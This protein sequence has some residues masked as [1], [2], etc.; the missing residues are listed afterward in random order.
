M[1]PIVLCAL[2]MLLYFINV[3]FATIMA[4]C[5]A[6]EMEKK[7]RCCIVPP[8]MEDMFNAHDLDRY[9][10]VFATVD[11]DG[12]GSVSPNEL[13]VFL[14]SF[15]RDSLDDEI[16]A[17]AQAIMV[18]IDIDNNQEIGKGTLPI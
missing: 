14:R 10:T 5:K 11:A 6:K 15:D 8:E 1:G 12:D 7:K 18:D 3:T 2:L 4:S 17:K 13:E 16:R 9:K